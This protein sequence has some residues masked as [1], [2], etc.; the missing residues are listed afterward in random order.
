MALFQ[1]IYIYDTMQDTVHV[2]V[3]SRGK[4]YYGLNFRCKKSSFDF[5]YVKMAVD[6][7]NQT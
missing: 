3:T 2:F 1:K 4:N 5:F 7:E 6:S